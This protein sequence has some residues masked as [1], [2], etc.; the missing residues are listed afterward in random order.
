MGRGKGG[1]GVVAGRGGVVGVG[2]D[3]V[4]DRGGVGGEKQTV[5]VEVVSDDLCVT[6]VFTLCERHDMHWDIFWQRAGVFHAAAGT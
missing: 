5:R 6:W 3:E 1:V 2:G 4:G